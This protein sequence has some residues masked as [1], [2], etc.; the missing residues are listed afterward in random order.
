MISRAGIR[1]LDGVRS[2]V[3]AVEGH[4]IDELLGGRLSR[5]EFLRRATVL[6]M[7]IP[8]AGG[9]LAACAGP[10]PG[11]APAAPA[12]PQQAGGTLRNAVNTPTAA[13]DPTKVA[14]NGGLVTMCQ[15]GEYLAYTDSNAGLRPVL[16]ERWAPD[17]TGGVWTFDIRQGV[18]FH[19]GAPLTAADVVATFDRLADPAN[20]S[21]ALSVFKG[22]LSKGGARAQ[23]NQVVFTLDR[24]N[25]NF[26]YLASSQNY[27]AIILPASYDPTRY[28][29]DFMGTGPY[30]FDSYT[31]GV[32]ASFVKNPTYWDATRQPFLDRVELKFY[33][34][35]PPQVVALQ[36]NEVD[37][38]SGISYS[39]GR[40]LFTDPA[41]TPLYV[42][43]TYTRQLSMRC[44]QAP[45]TD[46]RVRT[47][48]A[49]ALDRPAA[50][51]GLLDDKGV[52]GDDS[53]FAPLQPATDKTVEQRAQDLAKAKQLL[54]DAGL[55]GGFDATIAAPRVQEI[56]DLAVTLQNAAKEIGVRLTLDIQAP[57]D[58]YGDAVLGSSPWL[59]SQL[60]LV[61]YGHR[62]VPDVIAN[63]ALRSDGVW[64]AAHYN[65]PAYDA[66]FDDYTSQLDV[67]KQKEA[68]GKMQRLLLVDTPIIVPYFLDW[69]GATKKGV[70]G[71]NLNPT[72]QL[73]LSRASIA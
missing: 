23:G 66:L 7:S 63:A 70:Q 17:A 41:F 27:N 14:D 45:F 64:N 34:D 30:K 19:N 59:D 68:V 47:A 22:V 50:L 44:D 1:R 33:T 72:G 54:A 32:G 18:T 4:V 9:V 6:G 13:I 16:A 26:P 12:G 21:N 8:L 42:P 55:A 46:P 51:K 11:E 57:N 71:V 39:A 73:D 43:S 3:S 52:L 37:V 69:L 56:P 38:V 5:R 35:L 25:V 10:V 67:Q 62:S 58:Y 60:S 61:D 15:T 2:Q 48:L 65:S 40:G 28:T 20:G 24:P 36:G 31:P 49:L 53:P 29:T